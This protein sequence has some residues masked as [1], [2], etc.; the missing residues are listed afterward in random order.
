MNIAIKALN[1]MCEELFE[2][3]HSVEEIKNALE[4]A[5]KKW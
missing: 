1:E 4:E 2:R 5:L 3:G